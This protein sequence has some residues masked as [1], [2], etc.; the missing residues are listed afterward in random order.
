[1]K[2]NLIFKITKVNKEDN[3]KIVNIQSDMAKIRKYKSHARAQRKREYAVYDFEYN[4]D[5]EM[6]NFKN[7]Y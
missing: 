2:S 5:E 7:C 3:K 1:M 6:I 4:Y